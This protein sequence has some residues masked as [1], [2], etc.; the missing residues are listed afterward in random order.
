MKIICFIVLI[1]SFKF[2]L[3]NKLPIGIHTTIMKQ[4]VPAQPIVA[5]GVELPP[6]NVFHNPIWLNSNKSEDSNEEVNIQ[7][8]N[9]MN[10]KLDFELNKFKSFI[11]ESQMKGSNLNRNNFNNDSNSNNNNQN[12]NYNQENI[13]SFPK[14]SQIRSESKL[15][16]ENHNNLGLGYNFNDNNDFPKISSLEKKFLNSDLNFTSEKE[17]TPICIR[18]EGMLKIRDSD[19]KE[20]DVVVTYAILTKDRL[21]Y[22]VNSKDESSIQGSIELFRIKESL[23]LINGFPS[24][25]TIKTIDGISDCSICAESEDSAREWINS[26]TQNAVN[27]NTMSALNSL[28]KKE[29]LN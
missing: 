26:I 1:F 11:L 22:F 8:L 10:A 24:C 18:R 29:N 17:S 4:N 28:Q 5:N 12:Q 15:N 9:E 19:Q 7:K 3:M 25:F 21:S 16:S 2:S 13:N 14:F 23:K 20:K 27:C 6:V